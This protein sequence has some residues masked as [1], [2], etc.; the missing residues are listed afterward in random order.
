MQEPRVPE[1]EK[2]RIENLKA[3]KILDTE[4]EERFDRITRLA[5]RLLNVPIALVSLID[6]NR[7]WFKSCQGLNVKET[8]RKISFCGHAILEEDLFIIP[9]ATKD[10]RF[11]DNP[12]VIDEPKIRFYAGYP[13]KY[14]YDNSKLGTLCVIDVV[15]RN[16]NDEEKQALVDLGAMVEQELSSNKTATTDELTKISNRRGFLELAELSFRLHSKLDSEATLVLLDLNRFKYIND[17]FG[18]AEGDTALKVFTEIMMSSFRKS[19]ILARLGG[20]EFVIL[21]NNTGVSDAQFAID[22]FK[23]VIRLYN[24]ETNNNYDLSFSEG[25]IPLDCK[26]GKSIDDYLN[27]ADKLMYQ[28]KSESRNSDKS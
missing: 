17:N 21:L 12:L 5:K 10:E 14:S 2:K 3:L 9:D 25:I 4:S 1:N 19:D 15:A 22:D 8:S 16:L 24:M 6:E 23:E 18:H 11:F 28:H 7:Q 26:S 20:D 27:D 13:L